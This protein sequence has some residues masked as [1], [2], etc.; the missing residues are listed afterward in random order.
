LRTL[1][2]DFFAQFC[3]IAWVGPALV[4]LAATLCF[5]LLRLFLRR[6]QIPLATAIFAAVLVVA[7][8]PQRREAERWARV[9]YAAR[10][11]QWH[12]VVAAATPEAAAKDRVL[13][14]YALLAWSEMGQLPENIFRYPV[15][16]PE[17]LDLEG[18]ITRHGYY[19]AQ[20]NAECLGCTNE[21]IHHAFQTACTTPHGMSL[22]TLR[23]LIKYNIAA[24]NPVL[25]RKYCDILERNPMNA[26][27]AREARRYAEAMPAQSRL[28]AGP[29]EDAS[30]V[31]HNTFQTLRVMAQERLFTAA[32]ADRLRC[33]LLLQR[34]LRNF[35]ASFPPEEDIAALPLC[36]QQALCLVTDPAIQRRL[37]PAVLDAYRQYM[38]AY[39]Q[40]RMKDSEPIQPGTFWEYYFLGY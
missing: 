28:D 31:S 35:A 11:Q 9:E 2:G 25:V 14:P 33:L 7:L 30:I 8:L 12:K 37:S 24:G 38:E 17:D 29:S 3:R 5:L 23:Q 6:I 1:A 19:F 21:A 39:N 26:A 10:T 16:G 4:A 27:T 32:A 36:Y 20:M 15:S 40:V 34:D 22:G 13:I 18:E